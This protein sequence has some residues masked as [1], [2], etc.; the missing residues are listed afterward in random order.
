ML[1]TQTT[2]CLSLSLSPISLISPLNV[3]S[4]ASLIPRPEAPGFA[5]LCV[6]WLYDKHLDNTCLPP[7]LTY[8]HTNT[9]A[10]IHPQTH[11]KALSHTHTQTHRHSHTYTHT[12]THTPS[13]PPSPLLPTVTIRPLEAF[14]LSLPSIR[15][16]T[17]SSFNLISVLLPGRGSK[18]WFKLESGNRNTT[19]HYEISNTN[20]FVVP[21]WAFVV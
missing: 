10:R 19:G 17:L 16:L 18:S 3:H 15:L 8:T 4:R 1:T 5:C 21:S 20:I 11:T 7:G 6:P 14:L 13:L 2:R 9:Q 12:H